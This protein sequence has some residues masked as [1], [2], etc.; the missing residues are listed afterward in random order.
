MS[1]LDQQ[2]YPSHGPILEQPQ[3]IRTIAQQR[4]IIRQSSDT[5]SEDDVSI[6]TISDDRGPSIWCC[7]GKG[8]SQTQAEPSS[9]GQL[10]FDG[11]LKESCR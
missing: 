3:P 9:A 4:S 5:R 11:S 2:R 10:P 1:L 6:F 8:S 7:F